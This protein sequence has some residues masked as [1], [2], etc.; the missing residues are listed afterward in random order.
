MGSKTK[1][2]SEQQ[3]LMDQF[4]ALAVREELGTQRQPKDEEEAIR[5]ST[6]LRQIYDSAF[7]CHYKPHRK[8]QAF[9]Y[10]PTQVRGFFGSNQ[11]GKTTALLVEASCWALGFRPWSGEYIYDIYGKRVR[12]PVRIMVGAEDFSNAHAEVTIPKLQELLPWDM[13]KLK[14]EKT[15]G[16][17]VSK[18]VYPNGSHIK[19]MSYVMD[20]AKWEGPTYNLVCFDEPPPRHCWIGASRGAMRHGAPILFAMTPLKEPWIYEEIW[21]NK[22]AIEVYDMASSKKLDRQDYAVINVTIDEIDHLS[23]E[24]KDEFVSKLDPEEIEARA[25]GRFKHLQGRVFKGYEPEKHLIPVSRLESLR[26]PDGSRVDWRAWPSGV[27]LDPHDRKPWFLAFFVVSPRGEVIFIDEW[28]DFDFF[29]TKSWHWDVG[30]YLLEISRRK[31][32]LGLKNCC[33]YIIDPNFGPS[34]KITTMTS[35]QQELSNYEKHGDL[36]L[37]FDHYV[38]DSITEGHNRIRE[39]LKQDTLLVTENCENINRAFRMYSWEDYRGRI[40]EGKGPKEK[41]HEKYKDPIDVVR[42]TLMYDVG[43]YKG[44]DTRPTDRPDGENMGLGK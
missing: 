4:F 34:Q 28:P 11:S 42:Y 40:S 10:S 2:T 12:P 23:E 21:S 13:L 38:D 35:I 37:Y 26:N 9:H 8:Q 39:H 44:G 31:K 18:I 19:L 36:A 7:L 6:R 41:P 27:C 25:K 32:A 1:L 17:S 3:A 33:W 20:A 14:V 24:Q 15:Q 5:V 43:W 22:K 16:T 29:A 30:D